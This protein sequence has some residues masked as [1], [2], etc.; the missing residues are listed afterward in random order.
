M[1]TTFFETIRSISGTAAKV[2]YAREHHSSLEDQIVADAMDPAITYGITSKDIV[3]G[4]QLR[5]SHWMG[6]AYGGFHSLLRQL[7]ARKLTGNAAIEA[8]AD[9]LK[10]WDEPTRTLMKQVLDRDLKIGISWKTWRAEV[11][12]ITE[13]FEVALAQHLEKATNVNPIDGTYFASRKCD[14]LRCVA[15]VN[16]EEK[17]VEFRSR[18]NKVFTTLDNLKPAAARFCKSLMRSV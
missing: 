12:G 7:A 11:M 10:Y 2:A 18:Q 9:Y 15:I 17:T 14:G 13:K 8:I 16:L 6:S 1:N 5:D 3:V 4:P